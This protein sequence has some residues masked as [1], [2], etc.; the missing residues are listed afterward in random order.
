[1]HSCEGNIFSD[2]KLRHWKKCENVYGK[3]N[4]IDWFAQNDSSLPKNVELFERKQKIEKFFD[5]ISFECKHCSLPIV[6][7]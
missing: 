1:M 7:F 2:S 6:L 4:K 3:A 5:G